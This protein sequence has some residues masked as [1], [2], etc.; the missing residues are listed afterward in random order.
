MPKQKTVFPSESPVKYGEENEEDVEDED[1]PE[2]DD[3][4]EDK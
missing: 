1:S 2:D 3:F 4:P